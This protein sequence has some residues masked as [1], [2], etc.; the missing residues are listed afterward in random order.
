MDT[1]RQIPPRPTA[2]LDDLDL[3]PVRELRHRVLND[4]DQETVICS[5]RVQ[6]NYVDVSFPKAPSK[7]GSHAGSI[8]KI[9]SH[10][11]IHKSRNVTSQYLRSGSENDRATYASNQMAQSN[12]QNIADDGR[13]QFITQLL[14]RGVPV[15][16]EVPQDEL[17]SRGI[18][19]VDPCKHPTHH[20]T[21]IT[22]RSSQ[23][24]QRMSKVP[25]A[26]WEDV[27]E[28]SSQYSFEGGGPL[29]DAQIL[30]QRQK[31][32]SDLEHNEL[33]TPLSSSV[34]SSPS[35]T[36][37]NTVQA[38]PRRGEATVTNL[39]GSHD[40]RLPQHVDPRSTLDEHSSLENSQGSV[41]TQM[42]Q[43][44]CQEMHEA[45]MKEY[46]AEQERPLKILKRKFGGRLVDDSNVITA[47]S[48]RKGEKAVMDKFG[49]PPKVE[50]IKK[51]ESDN[52]EEEE[53]HEKEPTK[54][55][56]RKRDLSVPSQISEQPAKKSHKHPGKEEPSQENISAAPPKVRNY[57]V[58]EVRRFMEKKRR[59]RTKS[60]KEQKQREEMNQIEREDRLKVSKMFNFHFPQVGLAQLCLFN[61]LQQKVRRK[62]EKAVMDKFGSPPKVEGIKKRESDNKEEEE[63]HEK[64]PTKEAPRKRDL[65][66]PSQISEQPAKKSHKHPGKEEPS[67][68][69]IS[70]APPKVRNYEV[71]EVRRFMEKKRRERTKS[72]K[73]QKQREEMNQIEREDRLKKLAV[74]AKEAAVLKKAKETEDQVPL[75][76]ASTQINS[77][78]PTPP[79]WGCPSDC[80]HDAMQQHNAGNT[81]SKE[82]N[83]GP[84]LVSESPKNSAGNSFQS[85]ESKQ[86]HQNKLK[87]HSTQKEAQNG[88]PEKQRSKD[89]RLKKKKKLENVSSE[90][91]SDLVSRTIEECDKQLRSSSISLSG[92]STPT[93]LELSEGEIRSSSSISE[94]SSVDT[95]PDE[96]VIALDEM[97]QK[98]TSRITEEEMNLKQFVRM[99]KG[100]GVV[101][102]HEGQQASFEAE[103]EPNVVVR[104]KDVASGSGVGVGKARLDKRMSDSVPYSELEMFSVEQLKA[105]MTAMLLRNSSTIQPKPTQISNNSDKEEFNENLGDQVTR[106]TRHANIP[107]PPREEIPNLLI[108]DTPVLQL[109][110][111]RVPLGSG[112]FPKQ[113]DMD[114]ALNPR[115]VRHHKTLADG[116]LETLDKLPGNNLDV[117]SQSPVLVPSHHFQ[118]RSG[119]LF[120]LSE[121]NKFE[122]AAICIQ[123]AYRGHRVRKVT[124]YLLKNKSSTKNTTSLSKAR[125]SQKNSLDNNKYFRQLP[126]KL[127]AEED[128]QKT[129]EIDWVTVREE[130]G[131]ELNTPRRKCNHTFQRKDLPEWIKPYVLLS[132]SGNLDNFMMNDAKPDLDSSAVKSKQSSGPLKEVR[133][134]SPFESDSDKENVEEISDSMIN[135]TLTE[136]PIS[137]KEEKEVVSVS[138][139]ETQTLFKTQKQKKKTEEKIKSGMLARENMFVDMKSCYDEKSAILL[140]SSRMT[141]KECVLKESAAEGSLLSLDNKD[142]KREKIYKANETLNKNDTLEEGPLSDVDD[143]DADH[144]KG[145]VLLSPDDTGE[146]RHPN[147]SGTLESAEVSNHTSSHENVAPHHLLGEGPHFAP[148]NLRLRLNAELMYQDT[149]SEAL[150]Q[151]CEAERLHFFTRN[152]EKEFAV[153]QSLLAQQQEKE[154]YE[155]MRVEKEKQ[156]KV[157]EEERKVHK[158]LRR[159]KELQIQQEALS[160]VERIEKEAKERLDQLEKEVRARAEQIMIASQRPLEYTSTQPEFIATAAVAAVGATI[161]QWEK[162][163]E[164]QGM[165]SGIVE[166]QSSVTHSQVTSISNSQSQRHSDS[167][168]RSQSK[169][170]TSKSF[171]SKKTSGSGGEYSSVSEKV[172]IVS[173]GKS[174][175]IEELSS[176]NH[177]SS[178]SVEELVQSEIESARSVISES[179]RSVVSETARSVVSES[180]QS[181]VSESAV[182]VVSEVTKVSRSYTATK[183][184]SEI[185]EAESLKSVVASGPTV[186]TGSSICEEE[187]IRSSSGSQR[188]SRSKEKL[189]APHF[190][191]SRTS[192]DN[193]SEIPSVPDLSTGKNISKLSSVSLPSEVIETSNSGRGSSNILSSE[194]KE[195]ISCSLPN[196][197]KELGVSVVGSSTR[198]S[199][200]I[201]ESLVGAKPYVSQTSSRKSHSGNTQKDG[202]GGVHYSESF[203]VESVSDSSSKSLEIP[204]KRNEKEYQGDL[205]LVVSG[206]LLAAVDNQI[207]YKGSSHLGKNFPG[208]AL[209]EG[210]NHT[211]LG[212][213]LSLVESLQKEEEVRLQHLTALIKLQEQSLIEEA[214]WKIA[215]LQSEGGPRLRRRQDAVLRQLRE[216]RSHLHRL[217]ETQ[218]LAAQQ[219]R[220]LLLQH[221]H[222]LATTSSIS[223]SGNK[224]YPS[225]SRGHSPNPSSPRLTP[226]MMEISISSSSEGQEDLSLHLSVK[227]KETGSSSLS[228]SSGREKRRSHSDER[229]RIVSARLQ[230]KRRAVDA[231]PLQ[232]TKSLFDSQDKESIKTKRKIDMVTKRSREKREKS[233]I[234]SARI[235]ENTISTESSVPE[236][237]VDASTHE[238]QSSVAEEVGSESV[239]QSDVASS[240]SEHEGTVSRK[241]MSYS[242]PSEFVRTEKSSSVRE[243][244]T[245]SHRDE[246]PSTSK[247]INKQVKKSSSKTES[248]RESSRKS[249]VAPDSGSTIKTVSSESQ[250]TDK[251]SDVP[252]LLSD[253]VSDRTAG[254]KG[255]SDDTEGGS[256]PT[257]TQSSVQTSSVASEKHSK[258]K[259]D[260]STMEGNG[261]LKSNLSFSKNMSQGLET[262]S[263]ST[264]V[265][266]VKSTQRSSARALPL[267]LRVPLSPRSPHRQHRRYSSESDDSFTLSQTETASDVSDGE[268]KLIALKEQLAVRRAEADRLRREKRRLRRERLTSQ[269]QALRQQIAN[270]DAYIQQAKLELEKESKELQQASQVRPL[271]KKPQVAESKKL[272]QSE[273]SIISPEKSDISDTSVLSECSKSDQSVSSKSQEGRS[274][275]SFS[276]RLKNLKPDHTLPSKSQE[277]ESRTQPQ[278]QRVSDSQ[279]L[280]HKLDIDTS[281]KNEKKPSDIAKDDSR[282]IPSESP[283][284]TQEEVELSKESSTSISEDYSFED[285]SVSS[286]SVVDS[287]KGSL[288]RESSQDTDQSQS[289]ASSTETIVH[290]P[291]KLNSSQKDDEVSQSLEP[292]HNVPQ[293]EKSESVKHSEGS[294]IAGNLNDKSTDLQLPADEDVEKKLEIYIPTSDAKS[295]ADESSYQDKDTSADDSIS[296]EIAE[297]SQLEAIKDMILIILMKIFSKEI[298]Q[299]GDDQG[300]SFIISE[301]PE[302]FREADSPQDFEA[303]QEAPVIQD[304]KEVLQDQSD[305]V[306]QGT[307]LTKQ[308]EVDDISNGIFASLMKETTTL[309]TSIIKQKESNKEE[310][311]SSSAQIIA[312]REDLETDS[313]KSGSSLKKPVVLEH[314]QQG[315]PFVDVSSNNE[316]HSETVVDNKS[317][318]LKRVNDLIAENESSPRSLLNSPR[319]AGLQLT[320][321]LTFDISP[322]SLSPAPVSPSKVS[323]ELDPTENITESG[324]PC[325]AYDGEAADCNS[326]GA[327]PSHDIVKAEDYSLD[328]EF[329]GENFA[330]DP[331]TL[332]SKLLNLSSAADID[333]ESKLD[334]VEGN[335]EFAVEGIEGTWFDDNF[336]ASSDNKK[337]QQQ[338]KAEEERI[339]AEIA[340]LEELQRLQEQY[341][342]LVIR[343]V[344][345]KPPPPY[346]PPPS[347]PSPTQSMPPAYRPA[348]PEGQAAPEVQAP[349]SA[350]SMPHRLSKADLR[351]LATEI[352]HVVPSSQEEVI[353][354]VT[355]SFE[356]IY[357]SFEKGIDPSTVEPPS[358]FLPS[359][360]NTD[361]CDDTSEEEEESCARIFSLLIFSLT[362]ELLGEIYTLQRTPAPPRWIKQ[363]LPHSPLLMIAYTKS[364]GT[365]MNHV[366]DN[367]RCLFGWKIPV[368]KESLMLRWAR[369][370]RDLVDQVLVKEL[371]AEE[372]SWTCYDEDE[373][374]V[375]FRAADEIFTSLLDETISLF[376]KIIEKKMAFT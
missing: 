266:D 199:Q 209:V 268:G 218:N 197:S 205:S 366:I 330:I 262:T 329:E 150:N 208:S 357:A 119:H 77:K 368:G 354:L 145:A 193:L 204:Q 35:R 223:S 50:G 155:K 373:A 291:K 136:G 336:W 263:S 279:K 375:K 142:V 143:N 196:T 214:K 251:T 352:F 52:K 220:L 326:Q 120:N 88:T 247:T 109:S 41:H 238:S 345:N 149:V 174:S 110:G 11:R 99:N 372:A 328:M 327:S 318:V 122:M 177:S 154:E 86:G 73:E 70:A 56:P 97:A 6:F 42:D 344:P 280:T 349:S 23:R 82:K 311:F 141:S 301:E 226:R 115:F 317:Q 236:E 353:P 335:T 20:A 146:V 25:S 79:N 342:G 343:E 39:N 231:D 284:V 264:R 48:W 331:D 216:Q 169:I 346:T 92:I 54:E 51:R 315:K 57:E 347:S 338:L 116:K 260:I 319:A 359:S 249:S 224:G 69:N 190:R 221:H 173:K 14:R 161:S 267:P 250:E 308:R 312:S 108:P 282:K 46:Q 206:N 302:A 63:K 152:R 323:K 269:E 225:N 144:S 258:S 40:S 126:T 243:V 21:N 140:D 245:D 66:V 248:V 125:Q 203:E 44:S 22:A 62:G 100:K 306:S 104:T 307:T 160:T 43:V 158:E 253:K 239:S 27:A 89:R 355:E 84:K 364:K 183:S 207:G 147:F 337:K 252:T 93:S 130:L 185:Q 192:S 85:E 348:S 148:A 156:K 309:F 261:S 53:K 376:S 10:K 117:W 200:S 1:A 234:T 294:E 138:E 32:Q 340:R 363:S 65:S 5:P 219:R 12:Q 3:Q 230:E 283:Q 246:S 350:V 17:N 320:P 271:I 179:A 176:V 180:A 242:V 228:D 211:A 16:E 30:S 167:G 227:S 175:V 162:L 233:P 360:P 217:I 13:R 129:R 222:L 254:S 194:V 19:F 134:V 18:G 78:P 132:E 297:F 241:E 288:S 37:K 310:G 232:K 157:E 188:L 316:E 8:D 201:Q 133:S 289:Q 270:Y 171:S 45:D 80:S 29:P 58:T 7:K 113:K 34:S 47:K 191:K 124:N 240:V 259:E 164:I 295:E 210:G 72:H 131:L 166:S 298:S 28:G 151:L 71:T 351:K 81:Y 369:K 26:V 112:I 91:L 237:S 321:Q 265:S 181:V 106:R 300:Q 339:A 105:R 325:T 244:I 365:L 305:V 371:Q 64:E 257:G 292:S 213:T 96:R 172:S 276:S 94:S 215:A 123:A 370:H 118:S 61:F 235:G 293:V 74:K 356:S 255:F 275:H 114:A 38:F 313:Y 83:I 135:D 303:P 49:S 184:D 198:E 153:S 170:S 374:F 31:Y 107:S 128:I 341:P 229:K 277:F 60:H 332:T 195:S 285:E 187:K 178:S 98:L 68:E 304:R 287:Q 75:L 299:L 121:K 67:Q 334:L 273:S 168:T 186:N 9:K 36:S 4:I 362:R 90:S 15:W 95:V 361:H 24:N 290:S 87:E 324:I 165:Q 2:L 286:H 274:D 33:K 212:M 163:R 103:K 314:L 333:L 182:S 322:D 137:D 367:V 127:N 59:E 272:K 358:K 111:G 76:K 281:E 296:E 159:R 102:P 202:S 189:P 55:A 101:T 139:K 256:K 278:V